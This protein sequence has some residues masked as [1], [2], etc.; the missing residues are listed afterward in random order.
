MVTPGDDVSSP[1]ISFACRFFGHQEDVLFV[2]KAS[3]KAEP[4]KSWRC[5]FFPTCRSVLMEFYPSDVVS[6]LPGQK[7]FHL[8]TTQTYPSWHHFGMTV[9]TERVETSITV[10]QMSRRS[11]DRLQSTLTE[12]L[13]RTST[14][15][16]RLW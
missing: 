8:M 1:A 12:C 6:L 2:S 5:L 15:R 10:S 13:E 16:R 14:P 9:T 11:S 3:N 7:V 4:A